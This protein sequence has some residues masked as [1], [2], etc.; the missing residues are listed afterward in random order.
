VTQKS[1]LNNIKVHRS[2][3]LQNGIFTTMFNC[4]VRTY[5]QCKLLINSLLIIYIIHHKRERIFNQPQN[6]K[7]KTK[8]YREFLLCQVDIG[9][10]NPYTIIIYR[11]TIKN[12]R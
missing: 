3:V 4:E 7:Y 1:R 6:Q 10:W 9:K 12:K 2:V 11:K 8:K 5:Q